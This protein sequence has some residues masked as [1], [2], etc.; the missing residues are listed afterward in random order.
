MKTLSKTHPQAQ[1]YLHAGEYAVQRSQDVSFSQ[2]AVDHAIEQTL[3]KDTKTKRGIIGFS[4]NKGAVQRWILT[5]DERASILRNFKNM[6][7]ITEDIETTLKEARGP[8]IERDANDVIKVAELVENWG[9]PFEQSEELSSLSPGRIATKEI[10]DDLLSAKKTGEEATMTFM[11]ERVISNNEDFFSPI[12]K[13]KSKTFADFSKKSTIKLQNKEEILKADRTLF[14]RMAVVAQSREMDMQDVLKHSLGPLPWSL[15][16]VD[17]SYAK[18]S[19][20]K[21]A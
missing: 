5:A 6:L 1:H 8:R 19:K 15:A 21:F 12:T 18:T 16:A 10:S 14:A 2:V 11:K 3:N 17:G 9:N 4:L 7:Q 20:S 13:L